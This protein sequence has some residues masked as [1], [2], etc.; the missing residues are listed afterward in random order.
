M[1]HAELVTP[2][3]VVRTVR[4]R[5]QPA[6]TTLVEILIA[7][8]VLAVAAALTTPALLRSADLSETRP[9]T[10]ASLCTH[11]AHTSAPA[12]HS[13][14]SGVAR[15]VMTCLPNGVRLETVEPAVVT[16]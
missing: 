3:C 13:V 10:F 11:A 5:S 15:R 7:L 2:L 9:I 1:T 8:V 16:R 6:G 12:S 14:A 4:H